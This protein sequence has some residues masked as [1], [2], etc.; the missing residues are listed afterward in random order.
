[1]E[2]V[3]LLVAGIK[4]VLAFFGWAEKREEQKTGALKQQA[5][6]NAE[7]QQAEL[8]SAAAANRTDTDATYAQRVRDRYTDREGG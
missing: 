5:A 3:S 2:W 1:M 6:D 4:A 8:D 7:T